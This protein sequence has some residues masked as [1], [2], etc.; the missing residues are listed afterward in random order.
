FV[1]SDSMSFRK[2]LAIA[3]LVSV[4]CFS[5]SA[6]FAQSNFTQDQLK[7][8]VAPFA[9]FPDALVAQICAASTDPQQVLDVHDWLVQNGNLQGQALTDAAQ[10]HGFDPA[11]VSLVNFPTVLDMMANNI[12]DYAALGEAFHANQQ[13]VMSAIQTLRQDAFARGALDS[14][15]YQTVSVQQ[16][17]NVQVVV[18]QPTN[19]QVVFVPQYQPQQVWSSG[20]SS[21]DMIAASMLSFGAGIALGSWINGPQPWGWGGWGWGWGGRGMI[22]HNNVWVVNNRWHSPRNN[23]RPGPPR[24]NR[25]VYARP[26][27]NWNQRPGWRPPPSGWRPDGPNNRPGG[28][29]RPPTNPNRPGGN[30]GGNRPGGG[31]PGGNAGN[32]P[33][34]GNPG[35]NRPG[36]NAGNPGGNRPGGNTP[37]GRPGG[38]PGSAVPGGTRPPGNAGT[39]RPTTNPGR[40]PTNN[41]RPARNPY[42]GFPQR[43]GGGNN[44]PPQQQR[45]QQRPPQQAQSRPQTGA[46]PGG[47]AGNNNGGATRAASNRGRASS[48]GGGARQ[49]GQR[50]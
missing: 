41:T 33:G 10:Q 6:A 24:W 1:R 19:P 5:S 25:P 50:R 27:S 20:P 37:G 48:G 21:G 45:P 44:R 26:P 7:Q 36:G 31:N 18:V 29:N 34:G 9:L 35:G 42:A 47:F 28:G 40:P 4:G 11:F 15:E 3:L 13:Q 49:G 12:D 2:V 22:V 43:G 14:N 16:Q 30:P 32:R 38:N 46:R 39:G 23:W 17:G 8:L